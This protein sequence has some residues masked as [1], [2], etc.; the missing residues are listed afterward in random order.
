MKRLPLITLFCL[1]ALGL[2]VFSQ[3]QE[4]GGT[5]GLYGQRI[6]V[7]TGTNNTLTLADKLHHGLISPQENAEELAHWLAQMSDRKFEIET[8]ATHNPASAIYLL[9]TDSALVAATD[10]ERLKGKGLEAFILRGD[11]SKLQIIANDMRGL[12]YGVYFYLEQLGV[13]WLMAG[14]NWTVV[15]ARTGITLA[16]DRLVEPAFFSRVIGPSGGFYSYEL[17]R[18]YT[19]FPADKTKAW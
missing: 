10:K 15:P 3:N 1:V 13:R 4:T 18:S 12:T 17:G 16:I 6:V 7:E 8:A 5:G 11:S 19:G 2:N 9:R 14:A